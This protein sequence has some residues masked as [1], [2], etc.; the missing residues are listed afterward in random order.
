MLEKLKSLFSRKPQIVSEHD[1][2]F[3]K[4]MAS[5]INVNVDTQQIWYLIGPIRLQ[6]TKRQ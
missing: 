3:S 1:P 6:T 5:T 2:N 4:K